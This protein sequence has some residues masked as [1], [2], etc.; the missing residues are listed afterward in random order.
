MMQEHLSKID[1]IPI[2]FK[3]IDFYKSNNQNNEGGTKESVEPLR[4]SA[5][6][7]SLAC[8]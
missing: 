7:E 8:N 3:M 5:N 4:F 6:V 2:S 1:P